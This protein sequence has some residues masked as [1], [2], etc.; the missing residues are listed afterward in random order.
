RLA[1][2]REELS[3]HFQPIVHLA[4]GRLAE[5]EALARWREADGG[6]PGEFI[7][8]AEET[9]LIVPLGHWVLAQSCRRMADWRRRHP[10]RQDLSI[11]VNL[12]NKQFS[13]PDLIARIDAILAESGLPGDRLTLEI[14]ESVLMENSAKASGMLHE[15]L[16]R[17]IRLCVDDFGTG[18]SSLS[19]L[20]SFPLSRLKLDRSFVSRIAENE[21]NLEI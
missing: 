13:Q 21:R 19:Y 1:I 10:G 4:T 18:Y 11:S 14:T 12:S 20:H 15:L 9:G 17:G 2:E 7:P 6:S 16:A 3:L 8:V 5:L